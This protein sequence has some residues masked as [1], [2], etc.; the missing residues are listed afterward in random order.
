MKIN[1]LVRFKNKSFWLTFIPAMFLLVQT[2]AAMFG[3]QIE[4]LD[5][6]QTG[7]IKIVD[8]V[9]VI[10]ASL[11]IVVD[12]TTEGISDSDRA[13]GYDEPHKDE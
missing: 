2:I 4:R 11:G 13:L 10:L 9:F 8:V 5:E 7:M 6:F 12:H 1:W 3:F